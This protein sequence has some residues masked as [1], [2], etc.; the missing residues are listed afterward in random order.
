MYQSRV[1]Q[2]A[3][4]EAPK[5]ER[6]FDVKGRE[7]TNDVKKV[8][9]LTGN[10]VRAIRDII[11]SKL[12]VLRE[13][14]TSTADFGKGVDKIVA[15]I[16]DRAQGDKQVI[17]AL[18]TEVNKELYGIAGTGGTYIEQHHALMAIKETDP[19]MGALI[20]KLENHKDALDAQL[21]EP[22]KEKPQY[23]FQKETQP[24]E[25]ATANTASAPQNP[26]GEGKLRESQAY[27]R[28]VEHLQAENPEAAKALSETE[29]KYN[30]A[31]FEKQ[32]EAAMELV[33]KDPQKAY[34]IAKGIEN[35][36]EGLLQRPVNLALADRA[37]NEKNF[38][39]VADL[40]SS[41]SLAQT[42]RGQE[43]AYDRGR[44]D[45]NSPHKFIQ[46]VLDARLRRAGKDLITT[47]IDTTKK[48]GKAVD[49]SKQR[50]V[51]KIDAIA[52]KAVKFTQKERTKINFAQKL[53][54]DLT[55]K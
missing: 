16:T 53:L 42:R 41:G 33:A 8:K 22:A 20:D 5:T 23:A 3:I 14:A 46:E 48:L 29:V 54:D 40:E 31:N 2:P 55:C 9:P 45:S 19:E 4:S 47:A 7:T 26:V 37:F 43:I 52:E 18:R 13:T 17:S 6:T 32:A 11:E 24:K 12:K 30:R 10:E 27:K 39:M 1:A 34:L 15:D 51:A 21:L 38:Q 35:P 36:P 44:F 28:L 50:A 25:K 49:S